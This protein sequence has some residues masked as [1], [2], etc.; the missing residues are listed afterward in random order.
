MLRDHGGM[1][2]PGLATALEMDRTNLVG[3][4][5]ELERQGLV[6]RRRSPEDRRRH[7][8]EL[9]GAGAERLAEAEDDLAA[10]EDA[11]LGGLTEAERAT[12]YDLLRRATREHI[13]DCT[14]ASREWAAG[15]TRAGD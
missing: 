7:V 15:S 12:L 9:T 1:P 10:V 5:N 13:L 14:S 2:Q 11:V 4:L 3:L 8:V 6:E